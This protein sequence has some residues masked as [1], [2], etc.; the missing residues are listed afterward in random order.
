MC[1]QPRIVSYHPKHPE[2]RSQ[3]LSCLG[4]DLSNLDA[5][6]DAATLQSHGD[7]RR[8]SLREDTSDPIFEGE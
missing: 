7:R 8:I 5:I 2:G 1:F 3:S 6:A 4:H